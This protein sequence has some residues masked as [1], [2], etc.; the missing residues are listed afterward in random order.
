[1]STVISSRPSAYHGMHGYTTLKLLQTTACESHENKSE[2]GLNTPRWSLRRELFRLHK[3]FSLCPKN[4][5]ELRWPCWILCKKLFE[6]LYPLRLASGTIQHLCIGFHCRQVL[7]QHDKDLNS[8]MLLDDTINFSMTI[9]TLWGELCGG[10][11]SDASRNDRPLGIFL[12]C[13]IWYPCCLNDV[14][15]RTARMGIFLP[16]L[17]HGG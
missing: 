12:C 5:F 6:N 2:L 15:V 4:S 8:T 1:V 9:N 13:R 3:E 11:R 16:L 17:I 10:H 7:Y 14:F